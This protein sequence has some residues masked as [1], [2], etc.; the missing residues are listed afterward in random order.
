[1][2]VK[3][4]AVTEFRF[5]FEPSSNQNEKLAVITCKLLNSNDSV[6]ILEIKQFTGEEEKKL[7][8]YEKA[9]AIRDAFVQEHHEIKEI[10]C[11]LHGKRITVQPKGTV[12]EILQQIS[13]QI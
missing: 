9:E 8:L 2:A 6:W 4:Y 13:K 3:N 7:S 11:D 12:E 10:F 1:M 5:D